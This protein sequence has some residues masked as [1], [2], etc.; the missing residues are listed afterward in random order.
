MQTPGQI[1]VQAT[2][3]PPT[4]RDPGL[5]SRGCHPATGRRAAAAHLP[6]VAGLRAELGPRRRHQ[7]SRSAVRVQ[8]Q[9]RSTSDGGYSELATPE[10]KKAT[11]ALPARRVRVASGGQRLEACSDAQIALESNEP[12]A[13]PLASQIGTVKVT[14]PLLEESLEGQ[15]FLGEPECSP[16]TEA[17]QRRTHLPSLHPGALGKARDHDQ[18]AGHVQADPAT[19]QLTATFEENPQLPF[20]ELELDFKNGPRAP[21]ANPQTC[22]TFTTVSDLE[23]WSAPETPTAVSQ[24]PFAIT[25]CG[26]SLPFA[27]ASARAPLASC[28]RV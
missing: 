1:P 14:T 23:P 3:L 22:G 21:L 25:G 24:S 11:V 9:P 8:R 7:P 20:S 27:P 5:D 2:P 15:V 4:S 19:G 6:S 28:G 18:A 13:C 26:S 16:C 12:G 10:L 17:M